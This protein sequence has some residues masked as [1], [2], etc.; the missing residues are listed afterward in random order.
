MTSAVLIDDEAEVSVRGETVQIRTLRGRDGR[1]AGSECNVPLPTRGVSG[2]NF[3][4]LDRRGEIA[5]LAEPSPR[6]G[7]SSVVRIRDSQSS[8]GRYHFRLTWNDQGYSQND[9]GGFPGNNPRG[10]GYG[11][12]G[13]WGSQGLRFGTDDAINMCGDAVRNNISSRLRFNYDNVE[14]LNARPSNRGGW[15]GGIAGDAAV[16]RGSFSQLFT[17]D[18]QVDYS[19]GSI[20]SLDVRR[21]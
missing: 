14:I 9:R 5:L 13:R 15:N 8:E 4:V 3:Q 1:D 6:T 20:I 11:R 21:R 12:G 16:R 7:N 18:C 19:N 10:R 2:F 17:F